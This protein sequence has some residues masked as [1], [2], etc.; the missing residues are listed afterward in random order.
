MYLFTII[1][2]S[3][4]SVMNFAGKIAKV[5]KERAFSLFYFWEQSQDKVIINFALPWNESPGYGLFNV[6]TKA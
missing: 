6:G 3:R 5:R 2:T 1:V 4:F